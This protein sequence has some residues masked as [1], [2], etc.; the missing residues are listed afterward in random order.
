MNQFPVKNTLLGGVKWLHY[1]PESFAEALK[2]GHTLFLDF[3][4]DWCF[5]CLIY[6]KEVLYSEEISKLFLEKNILTMK[7]DW[8]KKDAN[9]VAHL[10]KLGRASVPTYVIYPA[11]KSNSPILLPEAISINTIK[12]YL[13]KSEKEAKFRF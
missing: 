7:A 4:A 8:T 2:S 5:T 9:I 10:R 11:G 6:E 12:E 1:T 3:G 13:A